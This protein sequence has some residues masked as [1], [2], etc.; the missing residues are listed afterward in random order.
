M[1]SL[2]RRAAIVAVVLVAFVGLATAPD[3][4]PV[5]QAE[6]SFERSGSTHQSNTSQSHL[7]EWV[8]GPIWDHCVEVNCG[9]A[10]YCCL[11]APPPE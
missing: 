10:E 5:R 8:D 6:A 11:L 3:F 2:A 9:D 4:Q 7:Y 1:D